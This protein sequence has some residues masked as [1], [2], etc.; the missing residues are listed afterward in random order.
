MAS[1]FCQALW[2][3]AMSGFIGEIKL[4][5]IKFKEMEAQQK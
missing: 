5:Q 2:N 1:K 3:F 4:M